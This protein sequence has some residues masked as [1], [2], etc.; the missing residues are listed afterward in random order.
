MASRRGVWAVTTLALM[1]GSFIA[2]VVLTPHLGTRDSAAPTPRVAIGDSVRGELRAGSPINL[3]DGSRY[4]HFRLDLGAPEILLLELEAPFAGSIT[5][6]DE[7][8]GL[9]AHEAPD[10]GVGSRPQVGFRA[11]AEGSY[12]VVVSG[13]DHR[14]FGPFTLSAQQVDL[15]QPDALV[16]AG[17]LR[18]WH[19]GSATTH[20]LEVTERAR[21][22]IALASDSFDTVLEVTG[23]GVSRE[24][25]DGGDGSNSLVETILEPGTYTLRVSA[26]GGESASG[27]YTLAVTSQPAPDMTGMVNQGPLPLDRM[28]TGWLEPRAPNTYTLQVDTRGPYTFDL[29]SD[30]FD[31]V[32][33]IEGQELLLEDDD[34]GEGTNS[35]LQADLPAGRYEVRVRAFGS[36]G[37]GTYT[38]VVR[39]GR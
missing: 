32:I 9:L 22:A 4:Q 12:T 14:G 8:N 3:K 13:Q 31:T 26:F 16:D 17:E 25:D 29:R 33:E 18:G 28:L 21:Y 24:D 7:N 23:N 35:R 30:D 36:E 11:P 10:A 6:L 19:E 38:L 34:G 1:G 39:Q 20:A 15:Q 2:G 5:V 37:P 27:L